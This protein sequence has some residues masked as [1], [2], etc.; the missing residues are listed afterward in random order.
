ME[1][2]VKSIPSFITCW[3]AHKGLTF[4]TAHHLA[5]SLT[6]CLFQIYFITQAFYHLYAEYYNT[7]PQAAIRDSTLYLLYNTIG[8][9]IYDTVVLIKQRE[10]QW[11][12]YTAHHIAGLGMLYI[13]IDQG[14]KETWNHNMVCVISE[15]INPA[16]NL[17]YALKQWFG[18]DSYIYTFN[19]YLIVVQYT[20]FRIIAFPIVAYNISP[21]IHGTTQFALIYTLTAA[22]YG[23]SI[24]WYRKLLQNLRVEKIEIT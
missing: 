3:T 12:L 21:Y 13:M 8:Y 16:L 14:I 4:I 9:F 5:S 18:R 22:L 19:R 7:T 2:I 1:L 23:A 11:A 20:V 10:S 24:M 17:R 6:C 15:I